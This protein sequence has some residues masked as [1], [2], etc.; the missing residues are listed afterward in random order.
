M[1]TSYFSRNIP[2]WKTY[3]TF[4]FLS[5][6]CRDKWNCMASNDTRFTSFLFGTVGTAISPCV[7]RHLPTDHLA[8][9]AAGTRQFLNSIISCPHSQIW[10]QHPRPCQ[11]GEQKNTTQLRCSWSSLRVQITLRAA[12]RWLSSTNDLLNGTIHPQKLCNPVGRMDLAQFFEDSN[13][14]PTDFISSYSSRHI[15][16][17]T[18]M[19]LPLWSTWTTKSRRRQSLGQDEIC[20]KKRFGVPSH[21]FVPE[22][23]MA[24]V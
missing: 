3:Q 23:S 2:W 17:H 13:N 18:T 24:Y 4:W 6:L 7:H 12:L 9:V 8:K 5:K 11:Q 15:I 22:L 14:S 19:I 1:V 20:Q 10:L 16:P 21:G